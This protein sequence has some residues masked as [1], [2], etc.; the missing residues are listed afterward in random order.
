MLPMSMNG[1]Q[2]LVFWGLV[3]NVNVVD[4]AVLLQT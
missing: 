4:K 2:E 1:M 3:I